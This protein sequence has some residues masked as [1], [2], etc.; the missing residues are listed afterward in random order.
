MTRPQLGIGDLLDQ[1]QIWISRDGDGLVENKITGMNL[2]HLLSLRRWLLENARK[3]HNSEVLALY[4]V[5]AMV[6]GEAASDDLDSAIGRAE[7]EDPVTW[8]RDKPLFRAL[9]Q[10]IH[11][12]Q[13]ATADPSARRHLSANERVQLLH[14]L[15][16][17]GRTILDVIAS[18]SPATGMSYMSVAQWNAQVDD[19]ARQIRELRRA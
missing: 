14:L 18:L 15:R 6:S 1:D 5:G 2:N 7:A 11:R 17:I 12:R 9:G 13:G 19:L 4:S 3:L 10:E 16:P 8:L